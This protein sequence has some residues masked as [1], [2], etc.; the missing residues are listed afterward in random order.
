VRKDGGELAQDDLGELA[1]EGDGVEE[2]KGL[3]FVEQ[4][5]RH[6][7]LKPR[8]Q[9]GAEGVEAPQELLA[10]VLEELLKTRWHTF[11]KVFYTAGTHSQ[12]S[13]IQ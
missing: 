8:Q 7:K 3:A 9:I 4:V 11:S 12:K 5:K 10:A 6:Y 1:G 13:S 2:V